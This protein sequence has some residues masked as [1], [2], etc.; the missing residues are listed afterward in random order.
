MRRSIKKLFVLCIIALV[1]I[2]S[3][4]WGEDA[5]PVT[6]ENE[7]SPPQMSERESEESKPAEVEENDEK[8]ADEELPAPVEKSEAAAVLSEEKPKTPGKEPELKEKNENKEVLNAEKQFVCSFSVNC[9]TV[10][11]NID[12]L[13]P[14]K[15]SLIPS[16]GILYE[17]EE[18]AFS[19]GDTVFDVLLREMTEAGIHMEFAKTP[20]YGN[21][22]IEGIGNFY[23]FDCGE[24]SGWMYRVNGVFP[25]YGCDGYKLTPG[26]KVEWVYTCNLGRDV[27]GDYFAQNGE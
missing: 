13:D 6:V 4:W 25:N 19:E 3:F 24:L 11:T 20:V 16:G 23:E 10:L 5:S 15:H 22:Y 18:V 26:D 2:A 27:G 9:N 14:E 21:V 12:R 17:R 8:K 7:V 1:L